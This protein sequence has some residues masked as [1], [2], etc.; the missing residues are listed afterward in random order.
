MISFFMLQ[1]VAM[2]AM[3]TDHVARSFLTDGSDLWMALTTVGRV[4]FLLYAFMIAEGFHHIEESPSRLKTHVAKLCVLA[5]VSEPVY[6][7]MTHGTWF[8]MAGQNVIWTL[9]LGLVGLVVAD[10][11]KEERPWLAAAY[12]LAATW[13]GYALRLDYGV[14][15]IPLIAFFGW[16]AETQ[17]GVPF[18]RR[19]AIL[20]AAIAVYHVA[21]MWEVSGFGSWEM[22]AMTFDYYRSRI[23]GHAGTMVIIAAY[24]GQ[25]GYAGKWFGWLYSSYYPLHMAAIAS[26]MLLG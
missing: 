6:D 9:L 24:G 12:Y 4:A 5:A 1:L 2:V 19:L 23:A 13:L 21:Y 17:R 7:L 16:F 8:D 3:T 18:V 15:G 14:V 11:H 25:R 10:R 22:F 26:V 20:L